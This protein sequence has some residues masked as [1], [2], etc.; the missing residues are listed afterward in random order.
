MRLDK[1]LKVSRIIKRRTISKDLVNL[2]RV[3]INGRIGKPGTQIKENDIL[4]IKLKNEFLTIKVL[5]TLD[6]VRAN[7]ATSMYEVIKEEFKE[8]NDDERNG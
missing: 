2:D 8:E 1:F 7:D 4:E 3:K 5:K 6:T